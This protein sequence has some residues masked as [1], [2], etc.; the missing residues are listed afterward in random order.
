[1]HVVTL[2]QCAEQPWKNGGGSTRELLAWPGAADWTLRLSVA[3][4]DRDGPFS[5][6][7]GISRWFTV[8]SGDGVELS[9]QGRTARLSPETT[10]MHFDGA[11]APG[12]RLL[13][14][15]TEDLNL[16]L[17]QDRVH[18]SLQ[19]AQPEHAWHAPAGWRG[20]YT[21]DACTLHADQTLALPAHSLAWDDQARGDVWR[22]QASRPVHAWWIH[23]EPIP[24]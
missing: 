15:A 22:L 14:G 21:A 13:G 17:R 20:L 8:L 11:T 10:P 3:R 6:Y 2:A 7:P 12:C 9:W 1:M 5:A 24:S 18:G 4:I 16:M 19:Q 23:M